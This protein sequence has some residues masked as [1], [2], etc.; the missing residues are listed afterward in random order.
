M[1]KNSSL[2]EKEIILSHADSLKVERLLAD[3]TLDYLSSWESGCY[4][5]LTVD[6]DD[7]GFVLCSSDVATVVNRCLC[8]T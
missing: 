7:L 3:K 5:A 6:G 4:R 1:N 8:R 2:S